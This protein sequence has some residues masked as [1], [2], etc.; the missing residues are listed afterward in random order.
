MRLAIGH[1][2]VMPW[3]WPTLHSLSVAQ[4]YP[5]FRRGWEN[6]AAAAEDIVKVMRHTMTKYDR[7][8]ALHNLVKYVEDHG[9]PGSLV[10]CGVWR[11]GSSGL[12][13]LANLRYGK[14][15]RPLALFD[16][17][18]DWPDPTPADGERYDEL[19]AGRL[20]KADNTDAFAAC[21]ELLERGIGYPADRIAYHSGLFQDTLPQ[22]ASALQPIAVLRIDCDWYEQVKLCLETLFP[23]V[24]PGG[25]VVFDD[26]GYCDGARRAVDEYLTRRGQPYLLHF[27]D[28]S[29]RYLVNL[30][31]SR[32][33][34][35]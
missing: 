34:T 28:Y 19:L 11:G 29:C 27:V 2:F 32:G 17:W 22:A 13:A 12:M 8:V 16:A 24:A 4:H 14:E 1:F 15:R 10:E 18:G 23:L 33:R 21:H 7:C 6:E 20:R 30:P 9:I 3:E 25:V 31:F 26:Y 5:D 35:S